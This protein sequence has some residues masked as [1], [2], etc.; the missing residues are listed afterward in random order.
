MKDVREERHYTGDVI[1]AEGQSHSQTTEGHSAYYFT[2]T[3]YAN[4]V[5]LGVGM[6]PIV[7][8]GRVEKKGQSFELCKA[9]T[10]F[11]QG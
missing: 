1:Y 10:I 8:G 4:T 6:Q 5:M 3:V 2:K 11:G 7:R 9:K